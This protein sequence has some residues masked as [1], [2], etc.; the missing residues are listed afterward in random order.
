MS[1]RARFAIRKEWTLFRRWLRVRQNRT[2]Q[3]PIIATIPK[4]HIQVRN[5]KLDKRSSHDENSSGL[6]RQF[7]IC[8]A[9]QQ[10][11]NSSVYLRGWCWWW[12]VERKKEKVK[13]LQIFYGQHLEGQKGFLCTCNWII[14]QKYFAKSMCN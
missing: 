1:P 7:S 14:M 10:N 6:G 5:N 4:I 11:R 9:R 8:F 12:W 2:I 3:F 13:F